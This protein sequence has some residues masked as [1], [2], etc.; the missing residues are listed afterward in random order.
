MRFATIFLLLFFLGLE[1]INK[2]NASQTFFSIPLVNENILGQNAT[3]DELFLLYTGAA[4]HLLQALADYAHGQSTPSFIFQVESKFSG[5]DHIE[6]PIFPISKTHH[7]LDNECFQ[8]ISKQVFNFIIDDKMQDQI[9]NFAHQLN[10]VIEQNAISIKADF[11]AQIALSDPYLQTWAAG[12]SEEPLNL[13]RNAPR[14][15]SNLAHLNSILPQNFSTFCIAKTIQNENSKTPSPK[16]LEILSLCIIAPPIPKYASRYLEGYGQPGMR[17]RKN[18]EPFIFEFHNY[19]YLKKNDFSDT[20][21]LSLP[22]KIISRNPENIGYFC[23]LLL[24]DEQSIIKS[25]DQIHQS[26][27]RL[28]KTSEMCTSEDYLE[29]KLEDLFFKNMDLKSSE[30]TKLVRSF[31]RKI[32]S[33]MDE[34]I[35]SIFN[36]SKS[37]ITNLFEIGVSIKN[38]ESGYKKTEHKKIWDFLKSNLFGE[39]IYICADRNQLSLIS[40]Q[41]GLEICLS[42]IENSLKGENSAFQEIKLREW[43]TKVQPNVLQNLMLV[44]KRLE[45]EPEKSRTNVLKEFNTVIENDLQNELSTAS[46]EKKIRIETL[47]NNIDDKITSATKIILND[48]PRP[49]EPVNPFAA[50]YH[51]KRSE[52]IEYAGR[53]CDEKATECQARNNI[54]GFMN[55][56]AAAACVPAVATGLDNNLFGSSDKAKA[57]QALDLA[58]RQKGMRLDEI[59]YPQGFKNTPEWNKY[60]QDKT[61]YE[62]WENKFNNAI[63]PIETKLKN[64]SQSQQQ[65]I[66][67]E[68]V[69]REK[70]ARKI[71]DEKKQALLDRYEAVKEAKN[72][73][74]MRLFTAL[75]NNCESPGKS[76]EEE[77]VNAQL[78]P[79]IELY[80]D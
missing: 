13:D 63:A 35:R 38:L 8:D 2:S 11:F 69:N 78:M 7:F 48:L 29:S 45:N 72:S 16:K 21:E 24:Q 43:E 60:Q 44:Q 32:S 62:D 30:K 50:E 4:P 64:E 28:L 71:A 12:Y 1:P 53:L 74:V 79:T 54:E 22:N 40:F 67:Q 31:Y 14:Y 66:N 58:Q 47:Q 49:R 34:N 37:P 36:G 68:Y 70:T 6:S 19:N 15:A 77:N 27:K 61:K 20:A 75:L 52:I 9:N 80:H 51:R 76:R 42:L 41:Q 33:T 57:Q 46:Q 65:K 10:K 55:W 23:E 59:S 25:Q 3:E 26:L 73:C 56:N 39:R 18:E 17:F 5:N